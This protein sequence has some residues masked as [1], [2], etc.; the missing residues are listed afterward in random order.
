MNKLGFEIKLDESF[1]KAVSLVTEALK[2]E[3]FGVLTEIDVQATLKIKLDQEFRPYKILGACNPQLA[4]QALSSVPEAGLLLP[5][6]VTVE[7]FEDGG[8]IVRILDPMIMVSVGEMAKNEALVD[9][10][11]KAHAKLKRVSE[12]LNNS[13]EN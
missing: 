10:A 2:T 12:K 6:N 13:L 3:G 11:H 4:H 7:S 5:C 1:E 8:A 9:V